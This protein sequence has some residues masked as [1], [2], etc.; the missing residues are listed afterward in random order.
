[1]ELKIRD[2]EPSIRSSCNPTGRGCFSPEAPSTPHAKDEEPARTKK[3]WTKEEFTL[4]LEERHLQR[5]FRPSPR[6]GEGRNTREKS[7]K[8]RDPG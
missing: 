6:E 2:P 4:L 7:A 1:M 3:K 5:I 8:R